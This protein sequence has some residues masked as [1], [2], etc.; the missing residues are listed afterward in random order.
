[1]KVSLEIETIDIRDKELA[2]FIQSTNI[3]EIKSMILDLLKKQIRSKNTPDKSGKWGAFAERMSGLTTP[4]ITER[5]RE[6]R[7]EVHDGFALR[8]ITSSG[9]TMQ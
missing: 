2:K 9:E 6:T 3:D 1:M 5:I 8:D 7:Q 4:E